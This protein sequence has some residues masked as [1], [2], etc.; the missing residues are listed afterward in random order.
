[1]TPPE[2]YTETVGRW[3]VTVWQ[4]ALGVWCYIAS[5]THLGKVFMTN[6]TIPAADR[7]RAIAQVKERLGIKE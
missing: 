7:T 3:T 6:D 1:M 4:F 5:T 2:K